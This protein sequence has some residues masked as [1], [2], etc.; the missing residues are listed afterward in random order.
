MGNWVPIFLGINMIDPTVPLIA[1]D[2]RC[3]RRCYDLLLV[4]NNLGN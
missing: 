3:E 2:D 4:K 1:V